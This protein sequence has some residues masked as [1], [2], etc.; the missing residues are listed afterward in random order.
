MKAAI[1]NLEPILESA[2]IESLSNY[3]SNNDGSFLGDLYFRYNENTKL[4]IYDDLENLLNE[5]TLQ[6]NQTTV[7]HALRHTLQKLEQKH[8][9]DKEYI[10][11]PFTI[12][13]IDDDFIT[14]EELIFIDDD[15]L[16]LEGDIWNSL[17][18]ELDNFLKDLMK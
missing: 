13:L 16:K 10:S 17:D 9:F 3:E 6:E 5:T 8:F 15:T 14:T 2:I 11:K 1:E 7:S 18:K 4:S 12:S